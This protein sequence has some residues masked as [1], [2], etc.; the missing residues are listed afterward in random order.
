M[1]VPQSRSFVM[2]TF[3]DLE[4]PLAASWGPLFGPAPPV[5]ATD[6]EYVMLAATLFGCCVYVQGGGEKIENS[7]VMTENSAFPCGVFSLISKT[8][9]QYVAAVV[10]VS[11]YALYSHRVTS[12]EIRNLLWLIIG[13]SV[14][15]TCMFRLLK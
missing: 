14:I 5:E 12:S 11:F 8:F 6:P 1:S 4:A 9:S 10:R 13:A 3:C 7:P 15:V 2:D